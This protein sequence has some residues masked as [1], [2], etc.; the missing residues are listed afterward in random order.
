MDR[1]GGVAGAT[2][3]DSIVVEGDWFAG[4]LTTVA[5]FSVAET[6]VAVR[7][8]GMRILMFE[9]QDMRGRTPVVMV[10]CRHLISLCASRGAFTG[11]LW[12]T[13]AHSQD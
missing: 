5:F 1:T 9:L 11:N 4:F 10:C 3:S 13:R 2:V 6:L 8:R 7:T 12:I